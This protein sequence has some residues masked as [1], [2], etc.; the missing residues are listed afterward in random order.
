MALTING[1]VGIETNT[2]TGKIKVGTHDDLQ[3]LHDGS[4]SYV[5]HNGEGHFYVQTSEAGVEDLYLQAGNDVYIRVQTGETAVKAIGDGGVELYHD[6]N[7]KIETTT[8]GVTVTGRIDAAADSAHDI[9]TTGVRFANA[10]VDTYYGDGSNLTGVSGGLSNSTTGSDNVLGGTNAGADLQAGAL[11]NT[12][13]GSSAGRYVTTGDD[14]IAIGSSAFIGTNAAA[15]TGNQNVCVGSYTGDAMTSGSD[16]VCVGYAAG[17]SLTTGGGNVFV[18]DDAGAATNTGGSNIA[19]G[20]N[21]LKVSTYRNTCVAVGEGALASMT[22][23]Y[24]NVA[25]GGY[26]LTDCEAG[27]QNTALGEHAGRYITSGDYNVCLGRYGGAGITEGNNNVAIGPYA[28]MGTVTGSNNIGV[29]Y[30]ALNDVTSGHTNTGVGYQAG[31]VIITGYNNT[32]LGNGA[33]TTSDASTNQFVLGNSSVSL[34]RCQQTSITALSDERDKTDITDL[35]LGL[36]FLKKIRPVK[37]KWD[38]REG[39]ARVAA[40]PPEPPLDRDGTYEAGFI[41]QEL[42]KVENDEGVASWMKLVH[43]ENPERLEATPGNLL[44][45]LVNAIKELSTKN[46]ALEARI[47]TLEA[48]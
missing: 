9:G 13:I 20:R 43:D 47:A 34:L 36:S 3:I 16:N 42:Q 40:D 15:V 23:G 46:D 19:I 1:T 32:C 27:Y 24:S 38:T 2:E 39:K 41:A 21:A 26:A 14:N 44:P 30:E 17:T 22:D 6:N 5:K 45:V 48:G 25:V 29:G 35:S 18:G 7:K 4:N 12:F 37:F 11:R 10:Y 8:N 28:L 33:D 31:D